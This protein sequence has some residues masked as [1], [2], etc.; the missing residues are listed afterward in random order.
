MGPLLPVGESVRCTG[1]IV[2]LSHCFIV[3]RCCDPCVSLDEAIITC[4]G[5]SVRHTDYIV[6]L[7]HNVLL[8]LDAVTPVSAWMRP[9]LPVG[10]S[11]RRTP[12]EMD[13]ETP[14]TT[15]LELPPTGVKVS[16]GKWHSPQ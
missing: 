16:A 5:E 4:G 8:C 15:Q 10:E 14:P 7:S 2:T 1:Y 9:L 11:V 12:A 13:C 3:F 6:T